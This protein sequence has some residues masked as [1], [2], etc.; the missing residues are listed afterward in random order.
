[1]TLVR[2]AASLLLDGG[3][4]LSLGGGALSAAQAA[5]RRVV[6]DL[7]V[8]EAHDRVDVLLWQ[9]SA[10]ADAEPG[11]KL[12]VGLGDGDAVSDVLTVEV[13]GCDTVLGD[14]A[15][16]GSDWSGLVLTGYAP[17]R[18]LSTTY[19]GR[20]Y[21]DRAVGD[22]V[23]DLL[24]EGGVDEGTVDPSLTL[25]LLHVDPR[26]SVW[27]HLHSLAYRF[28]CQ[29]T[30]NADGRVSFT[31]IPGA[32]R[33][34][35][36]PFSA[37][38]SA[39]AGALGLGASGEL[40]EGAELLAFRA[41]DRAA[42]T[43]IAVLSPVGSKPGLLVAEPDSGPEPPAQVDPAT[44]TQQAADAATTSR[45]AAARRRTRTASLTVPGRA[46]LR[47]G[48]TVKARAQDFRV[49]RARHVLDAD[50]GYTCTL[51]L[52]GAT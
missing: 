15:G 10:L 3:G 11:A 9:G 20:A 32:V 19:V 7:S 22:V 29:V 38:V 14:L 8:D 47:A 30:T 48:S 42:S 33:G 17:S 18:R 50:S 49:L 34:T 13:A 46:D 6:V 31:P 36:G 1:M 40:R 44:R 5:V 45:E 24:S 39:V 41:G 16:W 35:S 37:A 4:A 52:E 43:S 27:T 28:G 12:A 21:I 23:S 26:R 51:W 2:P 25:P